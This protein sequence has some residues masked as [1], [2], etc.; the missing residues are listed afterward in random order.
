MVAADWR[1]ET[2]RLV[3]CG[4]CYLDAEAR[5][6]R[7]TLKGTFLLQWRLTPPLKQWRIRRRDRRARRIWREL[8]MDEW[9]AQRQPLPPAQLQTPFA[10]PAAEA[11]LAGG[12]NDNP[13]DPLHYELALHE[14]EIRQERTSDGLVVRMGRK[15]LNSIR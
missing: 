14:G 8:G 4:Y 1:R 13:S 10:P 11:Q 3:Q 5:T 6:Y 7:K 15:S 2:L 12:I 9:M